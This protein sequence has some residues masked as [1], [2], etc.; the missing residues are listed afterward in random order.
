MTITDLGKPHVFA[1]IA[2]SLFQEDGKVRR[3]LLAT[4][5]VLHALV[6]NG[7]SRVVN[8]DLFVRLWT[9]VGGLA[10][11]VFA[12]LTYADLTVAVV[13]DGLGRGQILDVLVDRGRDVGLKGGLRTVEWGTDLAFVECFVRCNLLLY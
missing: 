13:V 1:L 8:A 7:R 9:V 6:E 5:P 10:A 4:R 11:L 2:P 3:L 12:A